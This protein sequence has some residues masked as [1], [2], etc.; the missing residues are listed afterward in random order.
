MGLTA[1]DVSLTH[2]ETYASAVA[3]AVGAVGSNG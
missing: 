2:T 3:V 1:W